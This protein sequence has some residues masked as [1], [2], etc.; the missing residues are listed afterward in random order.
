MSLVTAGII[1]FVAMFVLSLLWKRYH[2]PDFSIPGRPLS[3]TGLNTSIVVPPHVIQHALSSTPSECE[4]RFVT[5]GIRSTPLA[6]AAWDLH[7]SFSLYNMR[8]SDL[9]LYGLHAETY[10]DESPIDYN[11][12]LGDREPTKLYLDNSILR[13][14]RVYR[15]PPSGCLSIDLGLRMSSDDGPVVYV[16]GLFVDCHYVTT[17]GTIKKRFPSDSIYAVQTPDIQFV[18]VNNAH[19]KEKLADPRT[20]LETKRFISKLARYLVKHKARLESL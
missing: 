14:G 10:C 12:T 19:I 16:F 9:V 20:P 2:L 18:N 15:I 13:G 4:L 6:E 11:L 5:E 3:P 1:A 7:V 8:S 17:D